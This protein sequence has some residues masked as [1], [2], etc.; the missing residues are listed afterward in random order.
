MEWTKKILKKI[1]WY[2]RQGVSGVK[3]SLILLS[4]S[5]LCTQLDASSALTVKETVSLKDAGK[6]N[7]VVQ[8]GDV[9]TFTTAVTNSGDT[10]VEDAFLLTELPVV[11][12]LVPGSLKIDGAAASSPIYI[13][14]CE[15]NVACHGFS[16]AP[17][18]TTTVSFQ[19]SIN[20]APPAAFTRLK[21]SPEWSL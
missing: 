3:L 7:V 5:I 21:K 8:P 14:A 1:S 2:M 20:G 16:V 18:K 17:G 4:N 12:G 15:Q 13:S 9:V 10:A 6:K 11:C 19:A